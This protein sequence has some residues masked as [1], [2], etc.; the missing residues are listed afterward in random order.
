MIHQLRIYQIEPKLKDA[1]DERFREHALRI[2]K[3]YDFEVVAM[4]YSNFD[5]KTEFVYILRWPDEEAMRKQWAAFMAD[6]EWE[7]IKR[8]SRDKYGEMVLSKERDQ[9][10]EDVSWFNNGQMS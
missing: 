1:F 2:M 6:T 8:I 7:E 10:L 4:W 3:S 5:H 9:I